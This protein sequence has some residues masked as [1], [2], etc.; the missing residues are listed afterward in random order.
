ML[1]GLHFP[2]LTPPSLI[3]LLGKQRANNQKRREMKIRRREEEEEGGAR[4]REG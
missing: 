2:D 1:S 3:R 4:K